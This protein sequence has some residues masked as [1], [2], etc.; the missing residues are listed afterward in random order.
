MS[1]TMRWRYGDTSPVITK[2]VASAA[3]IEI[4]DLVEMD[5]SGNVTSAGAHTW[6]TNLATTQEEFHDNYLGVAMQRSR[7]GDTDPIRVAT[8]GVFEFECASST[9]ELGTLVGPAKQTGNLLENQT[10]ATVAG[11]QLAIGRV[12]RRLN[13]SGTKVLVD[14]TSTVLYGGPQPMA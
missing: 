7:A 14:V 12:A 4:G 3:V 6:N 1:D 11:E 5:G 10:V 2:A 8:T 13:P 9:F